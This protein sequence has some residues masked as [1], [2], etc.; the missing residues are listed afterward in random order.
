MSPNNVILR[1]STSAFDNKDY[2][3][4]KNFESLSAKSIKKSQKLTHRSSEKK[5][6]QDLSTLDVIAS[7]ACK[8][9]KKKAAREDVRS[10]VPVLQQPFDLEAK[11]PDET[12]F[13]SS[14]Q[15]VVVSPKTRAL[16][17]KSSLHSAK[18]TT[19]PN[20]PQRAYDGV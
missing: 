7:T 9:S 18:K 3:S 20:S 19:A 10:R 13:M 14:Q 4:K 6:N 12:Q 5:Q 17:P 16:M 2:M 8:D 15:R 1:M 11:L